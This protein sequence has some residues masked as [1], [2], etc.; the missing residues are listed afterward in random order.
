MKSKAKPAKG[1]ART[2]RFDVGGTVGALAGL[3]TLAYLMSR[4]KKGA[5]ESS[6]VAARRASGAYRGGAGTDTTTDTTTDNK[7]VVKPPPGVIFE[8][9]RARDEARRRA[10]DQ[11][12]NPRANYMPEGA[13]RKE[14]YS[15]VNARRTDIAP[16]VKKKKDASAYTGQGMAGSDKGGKKKAG[17][18]KAPAFTGTGMAGSDTGKK[19]PPVLKAGESKVV[20]EGELKPYPEAEAKARKAADRQKFLQSQAGINRRG[21]ATPGTA[22]AGDKSG[23][24]QKGRSE[25][26]IQGTLDNATRSTVRSDADKMRERALE[27]ERRRKKEEGK[28]A[29]GAVKKYAN[30]GSVM[31]SK[32]GSV[33]TAKP[34]MRSASSRA[35]GI[36]IRGKT[37]A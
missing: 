16:V 37:R 30:G 20:G 18:D 1:S 32:M 27:V 4:K 6:D 14:L 12:K 36:A 9:D 13:D 28:K 22:K 29:G 35:D 15:D 10:L 17:A 24:T 25:N 21:I 19:E 23:S 2:K 26:P 31:A 5:D 11:S 7:P 33:K 34:S 3:G 8:E